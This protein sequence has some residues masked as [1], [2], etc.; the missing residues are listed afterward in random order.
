MM[1]V[2]VLSLVSLSLCHPQ[3]TLDQGI[4]KGRVLKSRGGRDIL[5]FQ[6]IPYAKPPV[7]ELRFKVFI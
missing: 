3:V 2:L 1:L 5:S 7:N 6:G 4:L